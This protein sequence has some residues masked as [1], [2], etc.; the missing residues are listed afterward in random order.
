MVLLAASQ[1]GDAY[2]TIPISQGRNTVTPAQQA[3]RAVVKRSAG[4]AVASETL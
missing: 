1:L 2:I 3:A 4:F